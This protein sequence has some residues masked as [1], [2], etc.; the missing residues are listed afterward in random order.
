MNVVDLENGMMCRVLQSQEFSKPCI[1]D[2]SAL[3]PASEITEQ[4]KHLVAALLS[5]FAKPRENR[6]NCL[7]Q[8]GSEDPDRCRSGRQ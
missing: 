2:F 8:R 3:L 5:P 6:S 4:T 1:R 7:I